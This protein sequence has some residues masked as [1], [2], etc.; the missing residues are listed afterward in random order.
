MAEKTLSYSAQSLHLCLLGILR[1]MARNPFGLSI[2]Y[3]HS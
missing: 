1:G 2:Q 3:A